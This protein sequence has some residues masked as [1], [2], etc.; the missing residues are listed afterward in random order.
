VA[1]HVVGRIGDIP[2]GGAL[3]VELEGRSIGVFNVDGEI[4]A[5]RN[6]CSHQGGP[7]CTGDTLPTLRAEVLPSGRIREYWDESSPVVACPWHGWEY[8][9]RTG[10]LLGDPSR[11]VAVYETRVEQDEIRVVM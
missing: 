3:I 8:D 9:L 1:E 4:F 11:R 2:D 10:T 7:L 6:R 5:I